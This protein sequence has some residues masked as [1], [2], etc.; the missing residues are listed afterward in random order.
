MVE[1]TRCVTRHKR[2]VNPA[3]LEEQSY[4]EIH[5]TKHNSIQGCI[6]LRPL[7]YECQGVAM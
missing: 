1:W 6:A 5:A 4:L 2:D 3:H 7:A